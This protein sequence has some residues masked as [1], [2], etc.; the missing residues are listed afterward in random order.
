MELEKSIGS[1]MQEFAKGMSN[2]SFFHKHKILERCL[3]TVDPSSWISVPDTASSPEL[4][5]QTTAA[6]MQAYASHVQY[7]SP[8]GTYRSYSRTA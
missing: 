6:A 5:Q 2:T 8:T 1:R 7:F 4:P 3:Y